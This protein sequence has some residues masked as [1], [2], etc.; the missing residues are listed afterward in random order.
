MPVRLMPS[1]DQDADAAE[2]GDVGVAV[3]AGAARGAGG[4]EQSFAFVEPQGLH[5]HPG[6]FGGDGDAVDAGGA[7]AGRSGRPRS[8]RT[9]TRHEFSS[10]LLPPVCVR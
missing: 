10:I 7:V 5:A 9:L 6:Q 8:P 3:P 1:V 4:F 2:P